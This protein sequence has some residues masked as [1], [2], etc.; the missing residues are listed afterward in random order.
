MGLALMIV[1][2][3]KWRDLINSSSLTSLARAK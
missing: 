1:L 3:T 2:D